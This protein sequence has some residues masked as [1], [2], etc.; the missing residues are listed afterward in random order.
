[1]VAAEPPAG[2][3]AAE[4][5]PSPSR[6]GVYV[7]VPFCRKKCRYCGFYSGTWRGREA[8][9]LDALAREVAL[10]GLD[11]PA[12]DTCYIG[13]GTPSVVPDAGLER[14]VSTLAELAF[15]ADTERTLE[16]NPADV[17]LVRARRWRA[18]GCNRISVGVQSFRAEELRWLGRR[19]DP[20]GALR[21]VRALRAAGFDRLGL[22]L[23]QGLPGQSLEQRLVSLRRVIELEPEHVSCYELTAEAETPLGRDVAAGR[24]HLPEA[25]VAAEAYVVCSETLRQAG[26]LHYEVSNFAR[27]E[28]HCSRHNRKYWEQVPTLGLGPAAHS[29]DGRRR[30]ANV[31]SVDAYCE[32]LSAGDQATQQ[33]EHLD[34]EALRWERVALGLRTSRGIAK[35]DLGPDASARSTACELVAQGLLEVRADR[36]VPTLSGLLV[37]DALARRLLF[38]AAR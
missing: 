23:V 22:D 26:Y 11:W 33:T 15:S 17:T 31:R 10:R 14:L 13:G 37:A 8:A 2:P 28:E 34:A 9:Y 3:S 20:E 38:G 1:V 6:P 7:H 16:V 19:H 29:F 32:A 5:A 18:L 21:A 12:F 36:L 4:T 27:A 35:A 24:V 30:W 25:D